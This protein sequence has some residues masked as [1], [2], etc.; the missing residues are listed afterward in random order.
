MLTAGGGIHHA[1]VVGREKIPAKKFR[2][3]PSDDPDEDSDER[4]GEGFDEE[5]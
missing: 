5:Y 2:R 4:S 3:I 1:T